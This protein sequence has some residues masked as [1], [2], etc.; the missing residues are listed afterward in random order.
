MA[1]QVKVVLEENHSLVNQCKS[2]Q[3]AISELRTQHHSRGRQLT[4]EVN[5]PCKP[6]LVVASALEREMSQMEQD[7]KD[8]EFQLKQMKDS[9]VC[10]IHH[11][12]CIMGTSVGGASNLQSPDSLQHIAMYVVSQHN[13]SKQH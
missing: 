9:Q 6:W 3:R 8:V 11:L 1:S 5:T 12:S 10:F 4:L 2:Q 13:F 7:K